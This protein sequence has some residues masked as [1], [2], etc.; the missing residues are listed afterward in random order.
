MATLV[1]L[2]KPALGFPRRNP[3]GRWQGRCP[4]R[5]FPKLVGCCLLEDRFPIHPRPRGGR[6]V[7]PDLLGIDRR[8]AER[9]GEVGSDGLLVTAKPLVVFLFLMLHVLG[10][11]D[12]LDRRLDE[13]LEAEQGIPSR[14]PRAFLARRD[15]AFQ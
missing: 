14:A 2:V 6:K 9:Q 10:L 1:T 7:T 12:V 3:I 15:F 13:L 5:P 4:E 11:E 8:P